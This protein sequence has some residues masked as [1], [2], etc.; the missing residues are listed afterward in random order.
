MLR[1]IFKWFDNVIYRSIGIPSYMVF[2]FWA[3]ANVAKVRSTTYFFGSFACSSSPWTESSSFLSFKRRSLWPILL[4]TT[5]YI[6][7]CCFEFIGVSCCSVPCV[8]ITL[9]HVMSYCGS[10]MLYCYMLSRSLH[11]LWLHFCWFVPLAFTLRSFTLRAFL[12]RLLHCIHLLVVLCTGFGVAFF[13]SIFLFLELHVMRFRITISSFC[14]I[15]LSD[16]MFCRVAGV[17]T[18]SHI[19]LRLL[20]VAFA[21]VGTIQYFT[22]RNKCWG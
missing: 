2:E 1:Y 12:S 13:C 15:L 19:A 18:F 21:T 16:T 7:F 14:S 8:F 17:C 10:R 6:T 22:D 4:F 9:C 3:F 11:V 5:S 20:F